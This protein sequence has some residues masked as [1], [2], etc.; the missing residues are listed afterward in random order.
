LEEMG[1]CTPVLKSDVKQ[2]VVSCRWVDVNKGDDDHPM[3]R[4]RYVAREMRHMSSLSEGES[5]YAPTPPADSLKLLISLCVSP[6]PEVKAK[7]TLGFLDVSRAYF[8][9][10]IQRIVYIDLPEQHPLHSTHYG[11]LLRSMYGLRT[12]AKEWDG[13]VARVMGLLGFKRG[14]SS[15]CMYQHS[16]KSLSVSVHGDDFTC[17][18]E[19]SDI[20]W[21]H[22]E[23]NKHW[24]VK[25][26]GILGEEKC[27]EI[28]I[29]NRILRILPNG[30]FELEADPR[31]VQLVH[32]FLNFNEGTKALASPGTK[33][34]DEEM[35][36]EAGENTPLDKE[37]HTLFRSI[38]MRLAYLSA[39][40][41]DLSFSVKELARKM[42]EPG[43]HDWAK[44]KAVG[45]YLVG[46]PRA[47]LTFKPTKF[48][49][50]IVV[51]TD[52]DF[53]GC[54]ST[55][56]STSGGVCLLSG[57]LIKHWSSTQKIVSLS[58]GESEFYSLV[59]GCCAGL[60][61][62]ALAAD[63]GVKV[64]VDIAVDASAGK[65]LAERQGHGK[66]RHIETQYL[67][68][69]DALASKK[70]RRVSKIRTTD[71]RADLLTKYLPR[72]QTQLLLERMSVT[73]PAGR[74]HIA[75]RA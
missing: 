56:R 13:E 29:L 36:K 54:R 38:C 49:T 21:L 9:A 63:I 62:K 5:V 75:K 73:F 4:S 1:W 17:L 65:S 25:N 60:G 27:Q 48:S 46:C 69:Q 34:T 35:I 10:K 32:K 39:D 23:L 51:E 66:A 26:R 12:A 7:R 11:R 68:V 61:L 3:V 33:K 30:G 67:W 50:A 59:K 52:S 22:A 55:R 16:T 57:H 72:P 43:S 19:V 53:A 58:S 37:K 70:V 40:R 15:P 44:L 24:K 2:R 28:D 42:H 71:N 20:K 74:S 45:R 31:H 14:E 18:G 64:D 6:P 8:W 41:P 47:V